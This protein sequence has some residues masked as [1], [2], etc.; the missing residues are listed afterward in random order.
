MRLLFAL[1]A[2]AAPFAS[3]P[4]QSPSADDPRARPLGGRTDCRP[5]MVRPA[6]REWKGELRR[7]G[8]LPPGQLTL[9][10]FREVDGCPD[11]LIVRYGIGSPEARPPSADRQR[12]K[13]R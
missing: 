10:V 5:P 12:R 6:D 11:P 2:V 3:A 8:E 7:L 4:A 9:T 13:R 1:A